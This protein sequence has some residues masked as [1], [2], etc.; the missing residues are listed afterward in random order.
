MRTM[1]EHIINGTFVQFV[2]GFMKEVYPDENYSNWVSKSLSS[3]G[4]N[5]IES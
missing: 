4:I 5:L 3:V 2:K 1:R